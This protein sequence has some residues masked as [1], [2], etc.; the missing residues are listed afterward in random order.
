MNI[1]LRVWLARVRCVLAMALLTGAAAAQTPGTFEAASV[2]QT[3]GGPGVLPFVFVQT[4]RLRAPFATAREL[5]QAAYGLERNQVL[6][7]PDWLDRDHFDVNATMTAGTS[8]TAA[9]QL[10]RELLKERFGLVVRSARREMPVRFLDRTND[11]G[12]QLT[13]AGAECRPLKAPGGIP[14]PP[15]P[16]PPPPGSGPI[17]PLNQPPGSACGNVMFNGFLSMR[18]VPLVTF[19][20]NL[21]RQIRIPIVDRTGL[22]GLWDI[23]LVFL[24]DTGPMQF[25]GVA[26]NA[27]APSLQTAVREQLGLRL[28]A[29]RAPLD[30]VVIDRIHPPTEN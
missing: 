4:G 28:Q 29:G 27:D 16:P 21:S 30:V 18:A 15:P 2:R 24:P 22:Q 13:P 3:S 12:P 26:L 9:P 14:A 1:H 19:V 10:L 8:P 11:Q 7:G 20:V 25:N 6:G 17:V 23:D 5:V